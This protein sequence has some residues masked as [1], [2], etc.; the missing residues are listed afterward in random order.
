MGG[1]GILSEIENL[2]KALEMVTSSRGFYR[3][4]PEVRTNIVMAKEKA[5]TI[6]DV[7]GIPGRITVHKTE[8]FACREPDYGASSHLARLIIEIRKYDPSLRSAINLKY[9]EKIIEICDG[10]GLRVSYYDRRKEPEN[11]KEEEGATI[12][13]GVKVAIKRIGRVP[14]VIYHK[15]DWGKEPMIILLA[16]DAIEAA[17][18]AIKIGEKYSGG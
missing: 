15:G 6:D 2:K 13:W 8:V 18:T 17:K 7:A 14:D 3:L 9:D 10:M 4:I 16:A 1:Y 12:P 5:R 11:I